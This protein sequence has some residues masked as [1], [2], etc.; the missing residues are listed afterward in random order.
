VDPGAPPGALTPDAGAT[1]WALGAGT[2]DAPWQCSAPVAT[3]SRRSQLPVRMQKRDPRALPRK[4]RRCAAVQVAIHRYARWCAL[5]SLPRTLP[6][7]CATRRTR[8]SGRARSGSAPTTARVCPASLGNV[9]PIEW[10]A[11]SS[12]AAESVLV[13]GLRSANP[14]P[15]RRSRAS[16]RLEATTVTAPSPTSGRSTGW[17]SVATC[18]RERATA[19]RGSFG[20]CRNGR[21]LLQTTERINCSVANVARGRA[22][23]PG[24]GLAASMIAAIAR[25]TAG[26]ES[27]CRFAA[28]ARCRAGIPSFPAA[29]HD[30]ADAFA[31]G[32]ESAP[33]GGT[34]AAHDHPRR[35]A[36]HRSLGDRCVTRAR[37]GRAHPSRRGA[38]PHPV[39]RCVHA[40]GLRDHHRRFEVPRHTH[41]RYSGLVLPG[42]EDLVLA[43]RPAGTAFSVRDLLYTS[44]RGTGLDVVLLPGDARSTC[45]PR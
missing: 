12:V 43:R 23:R 38:E 20:F 34:G 14:P 8:A 18:A 10:A 6:P 40:R 27:N 13:R 39:R 26:G 41:P 37:E 21:R 44:V 29:S 33:P 31:L 25:V 19:P 11:A 9:A 36:R 42:L 7:L 4:R 2:V 35:R 28:V 5:G 15:L 16:R 45:P 32:L 1:R 30:S 24:G 22:P 3:L 17:Q